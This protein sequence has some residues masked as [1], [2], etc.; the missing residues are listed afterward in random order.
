MNRELVNEATKPSR[1]SD[2][3]ERQM[4]G[5][6][7]FMRWSDWMEPSIRE[8]NGDLNEYFNGFT[9]RIGHKK[10]AFDNCRTR[11]LFQIIGRK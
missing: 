10:T 11:F 5:M 7:Q 1:K 6:I 3:C 9:R 2:K 8:S 4:E